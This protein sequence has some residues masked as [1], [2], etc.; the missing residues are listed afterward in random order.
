MFILIG[1]SLAFSIDCIKAAEFM[2]TIPK[3]ICTDGYFQCA[4]HTICVP[5]H[6]NCD[7]K[8]DCPNG[9]DEQACDDQ[10]DDEYYDH[11]F[12][13][14]PAAEQDDWSGNI[15]SFVYNGTCQCRNED[16]YCTHQNLD[17]VPDDLPSAK[18]YLLDLTGNNFKNLTPE[19]MK[20]LSEPVEKMMLRYCN[21][22]E[23]HERAFFQLQDTTSLYLDNNYIK[24]IPKNIFPIRNKLQLLSF[25]F[26]HITKISTDAFAN[27]KHLIE[28][29]LRSNKI[30]EIDSEVFEPLV[31]LKILYLQKN[32]ISH[33]K[34]N[35]F[36]N[37]PLVQLSL[38]ENKINEMDPG[39]FSNLTSLKSLFLS[40]NRLTELKNGTFANLS[41]LEA[42]TLN[43]NFI[44]SIELGVF[45]DVPNLQ[46]LKLDGNQFRSLDKRILESSLNLETIYFDRF[47]MCSGA[48]H[49]RNCYPKGD[50]ISD[51]EHMLAN[52]VLRTCV[53]VMG[54]IGC[55]GNLI[56]LLCRRFA[57][58]TNIVH[59]LYLRNLALSDLLMG[60]YLF[61][62]AAGDSHY[63]GVYLK[64]EY[65]WRH[66]YT[67][68]LCGFLSTLSCESSVLILTLVTW[69]RFISVTQP[70]ARKQPSMKM[71]LVTLIT[72]WCFS[73]IIALAP[74]V[75]FTKEY[76]GEEFYGNNGVCLSLHIHEP[77]AK[78]W[79]YSAAM[80]ILINAFALVFICYAYFRMINEIK[81]SGVACRSTRQSQDTDKVAQRFGIIVIT[82]CLCWVPVILVKIVALS[83]ISIHQD[84]YAWLAI[85]VLPINS[86]LN[87]VL[88][89]L[90]TTI[91]KKQIRKMMNSCCR[92]GADQQH[93][94]TDSGF[95]LSFGVFP[96]R[97]S[98]KRILGY[99]GTQTSSL[100]GSKTSCKRSTAV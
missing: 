42:L 24:F 64:F 80:F 61:I 17:S 43:N 90:T 34:V 95:S 88:Y 21:I 63:R 35:S 2:K 23:I 99:R 53:W 47:E 81:S 15:C 75:D 60:I 13:K 85:F 44:K 40:T 79:Q 37:L 27:L 52:P 73:T 91:F 84:L 9:S 26:N 7:G 33:V 70:L 92:K 6:Q 50:G 74:L 57:P 18:I 100:T 8:D 58:K 4:N 5:Q 29:D 67:C 59:S 76:F 32:A 48:Q 1:L 31:N 69:D 54:A 28:L 20:Y 55:T 19:S 41:S 78:G 82:D 62:I 49:V 30:S 77:Y 93:T 46:S 56:V 3:G 72:L 71:A 39:C 98:T 96:I 11:L 16:L 22:E 83:G 51:Q 68:K 65:N 14:N 12:R 45:E 38:M 97:G 36:P 87:P 66:S 25:M 86:A 94:A 89:T 10:H